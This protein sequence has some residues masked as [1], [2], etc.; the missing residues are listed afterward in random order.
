MERITPIEVVYK[1]TSSS[2]S[3]S[4]LMVL[5]PL[6]LPTL[7][8]FHLSRSERMR[9][10]SSASKDRTALDSPDDEQDDEWVKERVASE[11]DDDDDDSDSVS[12]ADEEQDDAVTDVRDERKPIFWMDLMTRLR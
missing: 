1:I 12:D 5:Q 3:S 9:S 8:F 4:D 7:S 2:R 10:E 6:L 11:K